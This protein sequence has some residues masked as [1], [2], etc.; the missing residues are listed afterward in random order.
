MTFYVL[1]R[2]GVDDFLEI[3]RENFEVIVFTAR[4]RGYA[5]LVL[6]RLDEKSVIS[7]Q[8]YRDSCREIDGRSVK[9]LGNL[10][11]DLKSLRRLPFIP[12][13]SF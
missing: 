5:S 4:L 8:L 11:R 6:D 10:G 7:H 3:L 13:P 2:P 9:D 1:K 12:T